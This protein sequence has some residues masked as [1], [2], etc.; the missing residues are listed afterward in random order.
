MSV[1]AQDLYEA[2]ALH[3]HGMAACPYH[4]LPAA[5]QD[6]WKRAEELEP[7]H[8]EDCV[9]SECDPGHSTAYDTLDAKHEKL[10]EAVEKLK[11]ECEPLMKGARGLVKRALWERLDKATTLVRDI[12]V[13][14]D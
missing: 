13:D 3:M 9:C 6:A 4:M 10:K 1:T 11:E 14:D 7:D 2:W 5:E 8:G 12:K